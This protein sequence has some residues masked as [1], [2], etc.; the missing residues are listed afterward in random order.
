MKGAFGL[1][2]GYFNMVSPLVHLERKVSC[3]SHRGSY[4]DG[5]S[6]IKIHPPRIMKFTNPPL[7]RTSDF[8]SPRFREATS[9][10][11]SPSPGSVRLS[12]DFIQP[13]AKRP[14]PYS[15]R[16]LQI[17]S[18]L[19]EGY[20]SEGVAERLNISRE[21]VRTHRQHILRRSDRPNMIASITEAL[22]AEWI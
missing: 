20:S 21:T 10:P 12:P 6:K 4:T 19:A 1:T 3:V 15:N 2:N 7:T 11:A 9:H 22:R 13:P 5:I 18:M 8:L 17:L 16:Q 14:C